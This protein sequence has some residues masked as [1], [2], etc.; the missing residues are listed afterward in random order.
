MD[1]ND[2]RER[3]SPLKSRYREEPGSA[4]VTSRAEGRIAA[5]DVACSVAGWRGATEAGLH[6]ATGGDGSQA[7][8]ADMLLAAL[9]AC[10]G[11]TLKS[12][13]TAMGVTLRDAHVVAEGDWD[14]RGTLGVDREV[15]VGLTDVRLTFT[16][17]TDAEQATVDRLVELTERYCVIYRTLSQPPRL[18]VT[19]ER[20]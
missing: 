17:D 1:R 3:Q 12:V 13:A 2:L 20:P 14:A 5:D 19:T 15:P 6:P 8:S 9:V 10:A 16:L 7:C 11:V 4:R 18:T